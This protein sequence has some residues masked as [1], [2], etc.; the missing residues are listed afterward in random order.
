M[1]QVALAGLVLNKVISLKQAE[2]I[3]EYQIQFK[4]LLK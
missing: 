4:K 1:L 3:N 2:K